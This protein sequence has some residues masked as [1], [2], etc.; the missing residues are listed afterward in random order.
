MSPKVTCPSKPEGHGGR[1][2]GEWTTCPPKHWRRG[3]AVRPG[4][5]RRKKMS[6]LFTTIKKTIIV[7]GVFVFLFF[8][9]LILHYIFYG[10]CIGCQMQVIENVSKPI[11]LIFISDSK[12]APSDVRV[13]FRGKIDGTAKVALSYEGGKNLFQEK[14]IGPGS[15][16]T[17][18]GGDWYEEKCF[19]IY[20]PIDAKEGEIKV[21]GQIETIY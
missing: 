21:R 9:F 6:K 1:A 10:E 3:K 19:V 17:N 14:T 7:L 18:L 4:D 5:T 16:R 15:V 12:H 8:A 13:A 11:T 20:Q 2:Q